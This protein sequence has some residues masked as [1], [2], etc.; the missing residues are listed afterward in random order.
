MMLYAY[1]DDI[2]N[3]FTEGVGSS[4]AIGSVLIVSVAIVTLVCF[5]HI[6]KKKDME[7]V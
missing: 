1:L 6:S 5:H 7:E 4:M 3:A 2:I